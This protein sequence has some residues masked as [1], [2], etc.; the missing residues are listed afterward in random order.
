MNESAS[1]KK[2]PF[3]YNEKQDES[4]TFSLKDLDPEQMREINN[5]LMEYIEVPRAH[6]LPR[7]RY[8]PSPDMRP[9]ALMDDRL[10]DQQRQMLLQQ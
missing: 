3:E 6:S 1:K 8:V 5:L 9:E 7:R 10:D 4:K 2:R